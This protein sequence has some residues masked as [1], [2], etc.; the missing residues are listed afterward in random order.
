MAKTNKI[1]RRTLPDN[2]MA[3][4]QMIVAKNPISIVSDYYKLLR[5][6]KPLMISRI[7]DK[8]IANILEDVGLSSTQFYWRIKNHEAW[9]QEELIKLLKVLGI[10]TT[11]EKKVVL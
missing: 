10:E 4:L 2:I 9:T 5:L 7:E 6:I 3:E 1:V 8:L 11:N